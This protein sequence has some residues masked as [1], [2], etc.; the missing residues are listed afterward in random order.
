MWILTESCCAFL[1][2]TTSF[3]KGGTKTEPKFYTHFTQPPPVNK[4]YVHLYADEGQVIDCLPIA[5]GMT[6]DCHIHKKMGKPFG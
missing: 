4:K 2:N 3:L 6:G 5:R 1:G